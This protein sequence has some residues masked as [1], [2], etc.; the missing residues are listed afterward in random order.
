MHKSLSSNSSIA[1]VLIASITGVWVYLISDNPIKIVFSLIIGISCGIVAFFALINQEFAIQLNNPHLST[2]KLL[3]AA[4]L[5]LFGTYFVLPINSIFVNN[6]FSMGFLNW[7]TFAVSFLFT[8]FIPGFVVINLLGVHSRVPFSASVVFSVLVSMFATAMLWFFVKFFSLSGILPFCF[9]AL[10]Q[11]ILILLYSIKFRHP[12]SKPSLQKRILSLNVIFPLFAVISIFVSFIVLQEFVYQPFVRGDSWT[13]IG[14]SIAISRGIFSDIP[15]GWFYMGPAH[16]FDTFLSALTSLSGFPPVN[17]LMLF[18]V[19]FAIVFPLAFFVMCQKYME[20]AK[21]SILST[22]IFV[23]VS[24][25]GWLPFV[26]QKLGLAFSSYSPSQFLSVI[27]TLAPKVLNDITQP[28]GVFSE[29]IKTYGF[30]LLAIFVL[31]YLF[32]SDLPSKV[33][34]ALI[35]LT[36]AF[37]FEYH[38]EEAL[39]FTLAIVPAFLI[40]STK[41]KDLRNNLV[42]LI[43]G[44]VA[45]LLFNFFIANVSLQNV[46]FKTLLISLMV[47]ALYIGLTF[48]NFN[49]KTSLKI[50]FVKY[51]KLLLLLIFYAFGLAVYVL[52]FYGYPNM[53]SS[54]SSSIVGLSS[55]FPWY[56]Y[57]MS[58][59]VVGVLLLIGSLLDFE[60]YRNIS[61]FLLISV[62]LMIFGALLSL[63]NTYVFAIT[64]KE[65]RIIYRIIPAVSSVFAGW[66]LFKLI[67][68]ETSS[69]YLKFIRK[70]RSIRIN[71]SLVSVVALLSV[72]ILG[73]PSTLLASEYWM[74]SSVSPYGDL[75]SNAVDVELANFLSSLPVNSKVAVGEMNSNS[76]AIVHLAGGTTDTYPNLIKLDRPETIAIISRNDRYLLLDKTQDF[77][78]TITSVINS[79]PIV[80]NNSKY[81]VYEL[82]I[83]QPSSLQSDIGYVAPLQYSKATIPSYFVISSLNISYQ[84]VNNDI[85]GKSV[86]LLP[87]ELPRQPILKFNGDNQDVNLGNSNFTSNDFS[88]S[89]WFQTSAS[90]SDMS[91]IN[92]RLSGSSHAGYRIMILSDNSISAEINDGNGTIGVTGGVHNDGLW[93]NVIATFDQKYLSIYVDGKLE[94]ITKLP[95]ILTSISNRLDLTLGSETGVDFFFNGSLTNICL[96]NRALSENE[97]TSQ[98]L[99]F[100]SYLSN[101]GLSLWLPINEGIGNQLHEGFNQSSVGMIRN[102]T[103]SLENIP[104]DVTYVSSIDSLLNWV[105]AGGRL[106]AFGGKGDLND[107]LGLNDVEGYVQAIKI[108]VDQKSFELNESINVIPFAYPEGKA[109]ILGYYQ[110]NDEN[111]CPFAVEE[112][113]GQGSVLYLYLDPIYNNSL[114]EGE[115][116]FDSNFLSIINQAIDS[117]NAGDYSIVTSKEILGTQYAVNHWTG[118]TEKSFAAQGDIMINSTLSGSYFVPTSFLASKVSVGQNEVVNSFENQ[119]INNIIVNGTADLSIHADSLISIPSKNA[120]PSY[121]SVQ[122]TNCSVTIRP[123]AGSTVELRTDK[124]LITVSGGKSVTFDSNQAL[125]VINNPSI[126]VNGITNLTQKTSS[127]SEFNGETMLHLE[128]NDDNYLFFDQMVTPQVSQPDYSKQYNFPWSEILLSPF[129]I[130]LLSVLIFL[131]LM[132][133]KFRARL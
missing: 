78:P 33:R 81:A 125:L 74:V 8:F 93:H 52:V 83:L 21:Q 1:A 65:W 85:S 71:R 108:S 43:I 126:N 7:F 100:D 40:F 45:I 107:V 18:S 63:F 13:Y 130:I 49:L 46:I 2:T 27:N 120:I 57:P 55:S 14:N 60:K 66:A 86:L 79:L 121:F 47:L 99:P 77:K 31:L 10:F 19:V 58:L 123:V 15:A 129:N 17:S 111:I 95:R 90:K 98:S 133:I 76:D 113:F 117:W 54:Y 92:D 73:I 102:A 4:F 39:I 114:S 48:I 64:T 80:F 75:Q 12:I 26:S 69:F 67:N 104:S 70:T 38:I 61:L 29:G 68:V 37:A 84:L 59:G 116:L 118:H 28:Q 22:F 56:Y 34:I 11:F 50:F 89:A 25:F 41:I 106:I 96:Y 101:V 36:I 91:L 105:Q 24:G 97:I 32:K 16:F 20:N 103:W 119:A 3:I 131:G 23:L 35:A 109:R 127:T 88:I 6:W 53:T 128:Y 30:G 42:G 62:F 44:F 124:E 115:L 72:I 9:F 110:F 132:V 87:S 112:N 51:K 122:L 94:G 82:P 5:L